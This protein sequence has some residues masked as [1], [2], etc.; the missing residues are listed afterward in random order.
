MPE[1][2][3]NW[4]LCS[5][6]YIGAY[7]GEKRESGK[8]RRVYQHRWVWEAANGPIPEGHVIHHR[9]GDKADNRLENL[10]CVTKRE[11]SSGHNKGNTSNKGKKRELREVVCI[12]CGVTML[13]GH[14][15]KDQRCARCRS[16]KAERLRKVERQC[17]YCGKV[18]LS[19]R[20]RFCGQR[21]V[22]LG[23]RWKK[24]CI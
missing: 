11:H 12:D 15:R 24:L 5:N 23:G 9:N 22:N 1:G 6:G 2:S 14:G 20:G 17:E 4:T 19:V 21:C 18:M 8:R 16:A 3:T 10:E 13:R 7:I